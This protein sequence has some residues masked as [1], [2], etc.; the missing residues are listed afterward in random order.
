[1]TPRAPNRRQVTEPPDEAAPRGALS[2]EALMAA[3]ARGDRDAFNLLVE[4]HRDRVVALVC[5]FL[6]SDESEDVAQEAFLRLYR[7]RERYRPTARFTT[8]LYRLVANLCIEE[9]RRRRRR[10][11]SGEAEH[12]AV[13]RGGDEPERIALERE[14]SERVRGALAKLPENQ[15][16]AVLLCR[17][18]GRTY[19]EIAEVLGVSEKAVE[20][21]LYRAR[22]ALARELELEP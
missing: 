13:A 12:E 16:L 21:M 3:A 19:R 4:R 9:G 2:D 6:G 5:R 10:P 8:F 14:T 1:L 11:R 15:R 18:D 7:S 22:Q 20:A 17:F